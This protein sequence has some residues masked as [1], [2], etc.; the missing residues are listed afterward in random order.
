MVCKHCG[1]EFNDT[2]LQCP[3]CGSENRA[4]AKRQKK[5]ILRGY[6]KE[7]E[8]MRADAELY[9]EKAAKKITKK[10]LIIIGAVLLI[11]VLM[12]V[13]YL[14][15]SGQ[16]AKA[17]HAS[18]KKHEEHLEE[19]FRDGDYTGLIQYMKKEELYDR[20]YEKYGEVR[21]LYDK[22]LTMQISAEEAY[23]IIHD[24][25]LAERDVKDLASYWVEK[26]L[27]CANDTLCESTIYIDDKVFWGNEEVLK[28]IRD[29]VLQ[30][31]LIRGFTEEEIQALYEEDA[32]F[33]DAMINKVYGYEVER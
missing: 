32:V 1:A 16:Q 6:D 23:S 28:E 11:A 31:L 19:L 9:P 7:A 30:E 14:I 22:Y 20:D 2:L 21:Y 33:T 18:E 8:Q 5:K 12:I 10:L 15:V 17:N 29:E 13:L 27:R 26:F 4:E 25:Q 24:P 3:Y